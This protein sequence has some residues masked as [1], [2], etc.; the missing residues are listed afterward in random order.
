REALRGALGVDNGTSEAPAPGEDP[1]SSEA[2]RPDA[3]PDRIEPGPRADGSAWTPPP[4][5]SSRTDDRSV[6][7]QEELASVAVAPDTHRAHSD[8]IPGESS[9]GSTFSTS[10]V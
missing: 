9:L 4:A 10:P 1:P 6:E 3:A 8:G 2:E 5:G 7:P